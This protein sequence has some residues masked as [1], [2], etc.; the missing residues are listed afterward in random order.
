MAKDFA[1]SFYN[2][3]Q[4]KKCRQYIFNKYHGLCA[5][6]GEPGKIVHHKTYLTP[7]NIDNPDVTLNE[8][9]LVLLCKDC[10]EKIHSEAKSVIRD[11]LRFTSTGDIEP[12]APP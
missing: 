6:C 10:H 2:S 1:K 9:N 11:G 3:R 5:K 7:Y 4:W 8:D 12:I